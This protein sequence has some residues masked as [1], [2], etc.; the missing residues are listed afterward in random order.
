VSDVDAATRPKSVVVKMINGGE[1]VTLWKKLLLWSKM[2]WPD[3]PFVPNNIAE[4]AYRLR[5]Y[6]IG[7]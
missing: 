3:M 1:S 2:K 5:G 4:L 6:K 7:R